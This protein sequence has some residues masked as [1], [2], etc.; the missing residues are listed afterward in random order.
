MD[1]LSIAEVDALKIQFRHRKLSMI[2]Q[3]AACCHQ[4]MSAVFLARAR[5]SWPEW[6]CY[7]Y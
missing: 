7:C 1:A 5:L 2:D 3:L 6:S 4:R